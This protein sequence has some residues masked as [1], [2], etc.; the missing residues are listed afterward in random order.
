[1]I[2]SIIELLLAINCLILSIGLTRTNKKIKSMESLL[3]YLSLK[4]MM[5]DDDDRKRDLR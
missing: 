3:N 5:K 4:D 1:M 2:R